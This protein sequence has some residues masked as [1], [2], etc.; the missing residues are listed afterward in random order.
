MV[1]NDLGSIIIP[2]HG[3]LGQRGGDI[4][5]QACEPLNNNVKK[6][7]GVHVGF[8]CTFYL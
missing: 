2:T 6:Y 1:G 3:S 8:Y 7:M 5:V 4:A